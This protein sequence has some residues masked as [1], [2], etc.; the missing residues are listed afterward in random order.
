MKFQILKSI[1]GLYYYI[2]VGRNGEIMLTSEMMMQKQSC[3]KS[4]A[5]IKRSVGFF[6]RVEDRTG[7]NKTL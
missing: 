3:R 6:T 1:N 4:I 5:S 2:L 7:Q